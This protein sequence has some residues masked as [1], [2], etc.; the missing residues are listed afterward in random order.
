[1]RGLCQSVISHQKDQ[2]RRPA[3]RCNQY[4]YH[5][6]VFSV[7]PGIVVGSKLP[8]RLRGTGIATLGIHLEPYKKSGVLIVGIPVE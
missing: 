5:G 2:Y 1:M 7:E 3:I 8:P 4:E 6:M